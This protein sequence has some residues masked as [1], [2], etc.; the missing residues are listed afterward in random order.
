MI[1]FFRRRVA[2]SG[3]FLFVVMVSKMSSMSTMSR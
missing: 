1:S 2:V 3:A